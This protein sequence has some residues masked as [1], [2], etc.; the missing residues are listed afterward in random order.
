MIIIE[1]FII[2]KQTVLKSVNLH[3][4][5]NVGGFR[6]RSFVTIF[7]RWSVLAGKEF[8]LKMSSTLPASSCCMLAYTIIVNFDSWLRAFGDRFAAIYK[9]SFVFCLNSK[10]FDWLRMHH[11]DHK[12]PSSKELESPVGGSPAR[13]HTNSEKVK[14]GR[15]SLTPTHAAA[16]SSRSNTLS[17][18]PSKRS[19]AVSL[20]ATTC[21]KP[22]K[23]QVS[24]FL[25]KFGIPVTS[26]ATGVPTGPRHQSQSSSVLINAASELETGTNTTWLSNSLSGS[27]IPRV[28]SESV[29]MPTVDDSSGHEDSQFPTPSSSNEA[30]PKTDGEVDFT[31][32]SAAAVPA[33][34]AS[35]SNSC[36]SANH[37][38]PMCDSIFD[39]VRALSSFSASAWPTT[40]DLSI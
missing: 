31:V 19:S 24:S 18:R 8:L 26:G 40:N 7:A 39:L 34:K 2:H 17:K 27:A 3:F 25:N 38:V 32:P 1:F 4:Y 10:L 28:K 12:S 14:N 21:P 37:V 33:L 16:S 9:L 11:I 22:N 35:S 5:R 20:A 36:S 6:L 23:K 13:K 15:R 29:F 30:S